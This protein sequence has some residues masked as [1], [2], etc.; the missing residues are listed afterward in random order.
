MAEKQ[1]GTPRAP[2]ATPHPAPH[3]PDHHL[4]RRIGVG[5]YGEV[6]LARNVMGTF[7]AIKVVY[8][9][10]FSDARPYEREFA[11]IKAFEPVSRS[12]ESLMNI[13]QVGRGDQD[14]YF[15]YVMELA[16]DADQQFP[17][18]PPASDFHFDPETYAPKTLST[19]LRRLGRL[20]VETCLQLGLSLNRALGH[21]HRHGLLHRDLK[22]SNIIFVHNIPKLADIGLVTGVAEA[23]SYVGTEG[24]IPPEGPNSRQADLYGLGKVLYEIS[25]GKDRSDFP[26]PATTLGHDSDSEPLLELNAIILKACATDRS[27]RY[28]STDEMHVDL[29]RLQNGKSIRQ[30]RRLERQLALLARAGIVAAIAT[31]VASGAFLYQREQT[32]RTLALSENETR[33][34]KEAESE[35]QRAK[36]AEQTAKTEASRS[37]QIAQF[38]QDMLEGVGPAAALGR[39]TTMLREIM[40]QTARRLNDLNANPTVEADLRATLGKIYFDL[41]EYTNAAAMHRAALTLR[42]DALGNA[43]PDIAG[44]LSDLAEVFYRQDDS[45]DAEAMHREALA[46]RRNLMGNDHPSVA[47][48]LNHLAEALRRQ[49]QTRYGEAETLFREALAMRRKLLGDG[50]LDVAQSLNNLGMLL[51]VDGRVAEAEAMH[52]EALAVRRKLL[53]NLNPDVA[54]SLDRLGLALSSQDKYAEA[55]A[56]NREAIYIRRKLFGNDNPNLA[57]LLPRLDTPFSQLQRKNVTDAMYQEAVTMRRKLMSNERID[58]ADSL[59]TLTAMLLSQGKYAEALL[60]NRKAA[61]QGD[62]VAQY[63]LGDIYDHGQGVSKDTVAAFGWFRKAADQGHAEAQAILGRMYANGEVVATNPVEAVKWSRKAAEQGHRH[64]QCNLAN[65]YAKGN[66][67]SKDQSEAIKWYRLAADQ[68]HSGAQASLGHIYLNG[69]G[70]PRDEA[71]AARW[72]QKAAEQGDADAQANLG[73]MFQDGIGVSKDGFEAMKWFRLA[74]EQGHSD[75]Q[76]NLGNIYAAGNLVP[77]NPLQAAEWHR[78]AAEQFRRQAIIGDAGAQARLGWMY[79]KGT[80]VA[81]D[82]VE[83]TKW[84]RLAAEQGQPDAQDRLAVIYANGLGVLKD[85]NEAAR[86]KRGQ[87]SEAAHGK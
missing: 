67:V 38:L 71:K 75:A 52:R 73:Q 72:F 21:L 55:D 32:R 16:D 12:N 86:W 43:H 1:T 7:R 85:E 63:N 79:T 45:A 80:G 78:K 36:T 3:V 53:G 23:R 68:D 6:W 44:S 14:D 39:D 4:L 30:A 28:Q 26:E 41:G 27:E 8:R 29:V 51:W 49:G 60:L 17:I 62:R 20:P 50:H 19:E 64:A 13:L 35:R 54:I 9:D 77:Q 15:Y 42:K 82:L 87:N 47:R 10:N 74:A 84:F 76:N 2:A 48:S 5:A 66:G 58:E 70:V 25:M 56:V 34:R 37:R 81:Q 83:A 22:P 24:F 57:D 11:G 61:E 18:K 46:M 40:E 59:P 33:L 31:I 65:A 69:D